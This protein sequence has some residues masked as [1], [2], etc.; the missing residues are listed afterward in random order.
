VHTPKIL[1]ILLDVVALH[2]EVSLKL[3]VMEMKRLIGAEVQG[4]SW[5]ENLFEVLS[6]WKNFE[7]D[8]QRVFKQ[9]QKSQWMKLD[10]KEP[11]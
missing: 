1:D 2:T 7:Q 9:L 10:Q 4:T 8:V 3:A 5:Y 11:L 6:A